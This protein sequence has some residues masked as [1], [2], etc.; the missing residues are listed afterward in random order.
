M[1]DKLL[2]PPTSYLQHSITAIDEKKTLIHVLY[3][4]NKHHRSLLRVKHNKSSENIE[5]WKRLKTIN[6]LTNGTLRFIRKASQ[7]T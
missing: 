2:F 7:P 5:I 4:N 3:L 1:Y 6:M